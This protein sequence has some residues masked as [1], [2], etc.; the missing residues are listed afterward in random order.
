MP[1]DPKTSANSCPASGSSGPTRQGP[2]S[3]TVT[4]EPKRRNTWAS[5]TPMAP[6]PST[7]SDPGTSSVSMASRLVQ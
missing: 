6:P 1:S 3:S 5:S 7:A 4:S 2:A